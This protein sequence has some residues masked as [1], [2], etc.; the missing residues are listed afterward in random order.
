MR[1]R[2]SGRRN[3]NR[4]PIQR[5]Y[6]R[7]AAS[8]RRNIAA[9]L[10]RERLEEGLFKGLCGGVGVRHPWRGMRQG[11][12][13]SYQA[14]EG[15]KKKTPSAKMWLNLVGGAS[16]RPWYIAPLVGWNLGG[17][18]SRRHYSDR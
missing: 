11:A 17:P 10:S 1:P 15:A 8:S 4:A 5:G 7:P 2:L 9:P 12:M 14:L 6:S 13:P 16:S 3:D 18:D